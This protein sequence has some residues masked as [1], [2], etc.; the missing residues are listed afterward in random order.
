[1][2]LTLFW[3]RKNVGA[4][5]SGAHS[6]HYKGMDLTLQPACGDSKA[7]LSGEVVPPYYPCG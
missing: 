3:T 7:R 4:H 6:R 5:T 1:M 2:R